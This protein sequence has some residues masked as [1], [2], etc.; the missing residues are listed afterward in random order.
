[1]AAGPGADVGGAD[2]DGTQRVYLTVNN[3]AMPW[4]VPASARRPDGSFRLAPRQ[5]FGPGVLLLDTSDGAVLLPNGVDQ[6]CTVREDVP[7]ETVQFGVGG[8]LRPTPANFEVV[9]EVVPRPILP[10]EE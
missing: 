5:V 6:T 9:A 2:D 10:P 8:I 4:L 7:Y 3:A 1:M